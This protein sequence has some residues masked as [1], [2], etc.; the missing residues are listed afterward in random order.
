MYGHRRWEGKHLESVKSLSQVAISGDDSE[1]ILLPSFDL[2]DK[3]ELGKPLLM[4]EVDLGERLS[5][6]MF[7]S[8]NDLLYNDLN[9][10]NKRVK[11][12]RT[13]RSARPHNIIEKLTNTLKFLLNNDAGSTSWMTNK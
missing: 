8:D 7:P 12:S 9:M 4:Y 13:Y 2:L 1:S 3:S 5:R 11:F 6:R 10:R